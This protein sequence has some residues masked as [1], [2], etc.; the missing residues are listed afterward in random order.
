M[1]EVELDELVAR[2]A[3]ADEAA[4]RLFTC[5]VCPL[6]TILRGDGLYSNAI[7]GKSDTCGRRLHGWR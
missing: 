1:V 7:S 2:I 4:R 5:T 3:H 6:S